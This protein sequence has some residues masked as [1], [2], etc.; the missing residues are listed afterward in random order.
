MV[1]ASFNFDMANDLKT[2]ILPA[3]E[4]PLYSQRFGTSFKHFF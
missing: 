1:P 4:K 2:K 3:S